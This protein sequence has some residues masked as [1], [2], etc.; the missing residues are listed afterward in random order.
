MKEQVVVNLIEKWLNYKH[1]YHINIHGSTFS[2]N[3]T[4]DFITHDINGILVGI[5]AKVPGKAPVTTQWRQGISILKSGG[6]FVVAQDD[7]NLDMLDNEQLPILEITD[8]EFIARN[9]KINGTT[10]IILKGG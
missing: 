5:E 8:D 10:E 3:G 4:P 9:Y 2:K 1:R 6:R 7:F